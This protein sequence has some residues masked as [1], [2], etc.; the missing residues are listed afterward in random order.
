MYR[1]EFYAGTA[2]SKKKYMFG[3]E[4]ARL[5]VRDLLRDEFGGS[6]RYFADGD[7]LDSKTNQAEEEP[8]DVWRV[9]STPWVSEVEVSRLAKLIGHIYDQK[10]VL[11]TL[12]EVKGGFVP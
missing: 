6:T 7:W 11:W 12:E 2:A 5:L 10:S 3:L 4:E 9:L 1:M 8:V